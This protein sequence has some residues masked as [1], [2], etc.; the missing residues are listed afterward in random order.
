LENWLAGE[1]SYRVGV[2]GVAPVYL[3][4]FG[5][6]VDMCRVLSFSAIGVGMILM[7][8]LPESLVAVLTSNSRAHSLSLIPRLEESGLLA[9]F[10]GQFWTRTS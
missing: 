10:L 4:D 9:R 8:N 3:G 2:C 1:V 5:R 6:L 7:G